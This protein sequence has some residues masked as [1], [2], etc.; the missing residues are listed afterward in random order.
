MKLWMSFPTIPV[1]SMP[2]E[3]ERQ[4]EGLVKPLPTYGN[5]V[6]A[7]T[8][9]SLALQIF[10]EWSFH[11]SVCQDRHTWFT[12]SRSKMDG[13]NTSPVL[14]S[15]MAYYSN[16][17]KALKLKSHPLTVCIALLCRVQ[18]LACVYFFRGK[19]AAHN[20]KAC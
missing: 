2:Q 13:D 3:D 8:V 10:V 18:L 9:T 11:L 4:V 6:L 5:S 1:W 14:N 16:A 20:F 15:K 7:L 19:K 12:I 17:L